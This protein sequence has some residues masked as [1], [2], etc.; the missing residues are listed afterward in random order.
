MGNLIDA[1]SPETRPDPISSRNAADI[2]D[3]RKEIFVSRIL[4]RI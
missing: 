2:L 1:V 4:N 3:R